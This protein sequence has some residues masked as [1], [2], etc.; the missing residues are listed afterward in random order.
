MQLEPDTNSSLRLIPDAD[1]PEETR[2]KLQDLLNRKYIHIMSQNVTD[3]GRA[4]LIELDILMEGPTIES[5]LYTI[6]LKYQEFV[7]H[8]I[9]QLEEVGI[10]S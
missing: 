6:L 3:I 5:K 8:E 9:K 1:I 7:D 10:I 4:N 2:V